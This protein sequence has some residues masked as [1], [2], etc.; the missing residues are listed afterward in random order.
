MEPAKRART[1][2]D[3]ENTTC[4][5]CLELWTSQGDHQISSLACGHFFGF[6]CVER[7]L[8][9]GHKQCP[10]CKLEMKRSQIRRHFV[11]SVLTVQDSAREERLARQLAEERALRITAEMSQAT[12]QAKIMQLEASLASRPKPHS[13][14]SAPSSAPSSQDNNDQ[15]LARIPIAINNARAACWIGPERG[16]I[17]TAYMD[18]KYILHNI[19]PDFPDRKIVVAGGKGLAAIKDIAMCPSS[20]VA[21]GGCLAVASMDS[22]IRLVSAQNF[23]E[24]GTYELGSGEQAW[25][26]CFASDTMLMV[27]LA[28]GRV[29]SL[30]PRM[31]KSPISITQA[32]YH[33]TE[34]VHSLCAV[35]Q[36]SALAATF[37]SISLVS[38]T[39]S[40]AMAVVNGIALRPMGLQYSSIV[41][42]P[43]SSNGYSSKVA[44]SLRGGGQDSF[45]EVGELV[46]GSFV[47]TKL[48]ANLSPPSGRIAFNN[49]QVF[50]PTLQSLCLL[51]PSS[52]TPVY[53]KSNLSGAWLCQD[54][55]LMLLSPHHVDFLAISN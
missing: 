51:P 21:Y 42:H 3:N 49:R 41:N 52:A 35:G 13:P 15:V 55:R 43:V 39:A 44:I 8:L 29:A 7:A 50:V 9:M 30:D 5:I 31:P 32:N 14:V 18:N 48:F 36:A 34:P 53:T 38:S 26:A 45:V 4:P 33:C 20:A 6:H 54:D 47:Q 11:S 1:D 12:S 16:A 2:S 25:S 37:T 27:G 40:E 23:N 22:Q 10:T 28:R 24:I 17:V 46:Q 19:H